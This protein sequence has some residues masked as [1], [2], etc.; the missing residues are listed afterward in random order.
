L[1]A[2]HRHGSGLKN[3]QAYAN[4]V[5][6][7]DHTA[8]LLSCHVSNHRSRLFLIAEKCPTESRSVATFFIV[9]NFLQ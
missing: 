3:Q 8:S 5:P 9:N 6:V 7:S 1:A 4:E 2:T